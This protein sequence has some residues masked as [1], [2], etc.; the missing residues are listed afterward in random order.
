[1]KTFGMETSIQTFYVDRGGI[2]AY[3]TVKAH[4]WMVEDGCLVFYTN[5]DPVLA[6]AVGTWVSVGESKS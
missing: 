3:K 5:G 1:M 2:A 4:Y 6:Y